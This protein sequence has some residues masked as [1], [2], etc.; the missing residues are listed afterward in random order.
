MK[1]SEIVKE[2]I[3]DKKVLND[4]ETE[5]EIDTAKK[6][7]NIQYS[8]QSFKF[9]M[10]AITLMVVLSIITVATFTFMMRLSTEVDE[11][12]DVNYEQ[13]YVFIVDDKDSAFWKSVY[14]GANEQ[15]KADHIY[16]EDLSE[17]LGVN[18]TDVDLLRIAVNSSVDGIIYGGSASE[19]SEELIN[20]AVSEGIGVTI[21]QKDMESSQRQCFVGSNNYE[22]GQIYG[23]QILSAV[24][25]DNV[26]GSSVEILVDGDMSEGAVNILIMGIDEYILGELGNP[27]DGSSTLNIEV[28]RI[29]A[30]DV[31]SVDETIREIYLDR[32]QLPDVMICLSSIYTQCVYQ[33][34]VDYN[35]VGQTSIIGY[36]ADDATI[37]AIEKR[38]IFS[39]ITIDTREMGSQAVVALEEYHTH[40][41]T[42]SFVSVGTE[43]YDIEKIDSLKMSEEVEADD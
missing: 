40:G 21:L 29:Y 31:F 12:Q 3:N 34:V 17:T 14:E 13:H 10:A 26:Y 16:L 2:E 5:A 25:K 8:G 4:A 33:A 1:K 23:S 24:G 37:D 9:I 18:Y 19:Q 42:N 28:T 41:Y 6:M 11:I 15:A 38:V 20:K 7:K 32:E 39:T 35:K 36:Y 43:V 30:K 27:L 22:L